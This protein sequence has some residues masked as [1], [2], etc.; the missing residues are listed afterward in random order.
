MVDHALVEGHISN[1]VQ[2]AQIELQE[3][4]VFV[5]VFVFQDN[6]LG[7]WE[8]LGRIWEGIDWGRV[9]YDQN[10]LYEFLKELI[11]NQK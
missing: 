3:A 9:E 1:G 7:R 4:F 10:T 5:F 2:T 11:K 8:E 6:K